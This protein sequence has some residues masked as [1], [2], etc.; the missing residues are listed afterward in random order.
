MLRFSELKFALIFS[1][2][3]PELALLTESWTLS[4]LINNFT[5]SFLSK[6]TLATLSIEA[7]EKHER[8]EKIFVD[9]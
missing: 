5:P 6:D 8:N 1:F 2:P 9:D 4:L 7:Q 3:S